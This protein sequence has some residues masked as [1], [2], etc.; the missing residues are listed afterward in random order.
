MTLWRVLQNLEK[1]AR[2]MWGALCLP[3]P[4]RASYGCRD[5]LGAMLGTENPT[6]SKSSLALEKLC[7]PS[8]WGDR[9]HSYERVCRG[10]HGSRALKS[11]GLC[12]LSS[13]AWVRGRMLEG[14]FLS[15]Q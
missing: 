2:V 13:G 15:P 6:A 4:T 8:P 9:R 14:A 11:V 5:V 1:G 7:P 10:R 12:R 3:P